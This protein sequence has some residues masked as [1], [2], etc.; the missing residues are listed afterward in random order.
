[1]RNWGMSTG[2]IK[3]VYFET[4]FKTFL[5]TGWALVGLVGSTIF[6]FE[7][8]NLLFRLGIFLWVIRLVQFC[9]VEEV[10]HGVINH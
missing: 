6:C 8:K 10:M 7:S 9:H 5:K 4:F 1:M 3:G 2:I